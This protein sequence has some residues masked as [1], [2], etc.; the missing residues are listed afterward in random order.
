ML[1][2]HALKGFTGEAGVMPAKGGRTDLD[3]NL[4]RAGVDYMVS[5]SH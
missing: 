1:Y 5:Q 4:I 3:D 2:L